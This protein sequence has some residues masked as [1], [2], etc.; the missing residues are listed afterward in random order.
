MSRA[1]VDWY[2]LP[3]LEKDT[4]VTIIGPQ[5]PRLTIVNASRKTVAEITTSADGSRTALL[6]AN[7]ESYLYVYGS[8]EYELKLQP[9]ITDFTTPRSG[10]SALELT[11]GKV[12]EV[13]AYDELNQQ[14]STIVQVTNPEDVP[15]RITLEAEITDPKWQ[16]H[17]N[18]KELEIPAGGSAQ[19]D[20]T[21]NVSPDAWPD[22]PARV[23]VRGLDAENNVTSATAPVSA[24]RSI[25]PVVPSSLPQLPTTLV[26]SINVA[27]SKL[28]AQW[29]NP[30]DKAEALNDDILALG[31]YFQI[32]RISPTGPA[33]NS[34]TLELA[35]TQ[36]V[37]VIG[38][39]FTPFGLQ[40]GQPAQRNATR[41]KVLLSVD[42][43][44]Y[45][46]SVTVDLI[47]QTR[48]QYVVL[49]QPVKARFAQLQLVDSL[50]QYLIA[51]GEWQVLASAESA[52]TALPKNIADP[53]LGGHVV[54]VEPPWPNTSYDVT[55]LTEKEDAQSIRVYQDTSVAFA[56]GFE[57]NRAAHIE[58]LEWVQTGQAFD[59][60]HVWTS[61]E[62]P[63]GPWQKLGTWPISAGTNQ[64]DLPQ[65]I[66]ARFLKFEPTTTINTGASV[67]TP[68]ILR[69]IEHRPT[70]G[71]SILGSWGYNANSGPYDLQT[72]KQVDAVDVGQ[73]AHTSR[74][75]AQNLLLDTRVA[76]VVRLGHFENWYRLNVPE[77]HN[78]L[79]VSLDGDSN[80]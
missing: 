22:H 72:P 42:G 5:D 31:H 18:T 59:D 24:L 35:G 77:G 1:S 78:T 33:T 38:F 48:P 4:K 44:D 16:A 14:V 25:H 76:S 10:R 27:A 54:W 61:T 74:D 79:Q 53:A 3:E 45:Q 63:F 19:T 62:S 75:N 69:V 58:R 17:L 13:A 30:A 11:I 55:M 57:H 23:I 71:S 41:V 2:R 6:P 20:L 49:P 64:W 66:W 26:G 15:H 39:A 37:D 51:L 9:E 21:L 46:E 29:I 60:V 73:P 7:T 34:Q 68:D 47:A 50:D 70:A 32:K 52:A 65:S 28:G 43:T 56:I 67:T 36:P 80:S 12:P 8:G 40:D